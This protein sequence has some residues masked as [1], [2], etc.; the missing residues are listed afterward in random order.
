MKRLRCRENKLRVKH[1]YT[2]MQ[3]SRTEEDKKKTYHKIV[4]KELLWAE[5]EKQ[6][7]WR[8]LTGNFSIFHYSYPFT[9]K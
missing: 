6:R 4:L 8:A 9:I 1:I 3:S 2:Q 7:G 5:G